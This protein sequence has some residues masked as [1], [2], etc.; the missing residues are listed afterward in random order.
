MCLYKSEIHHCL[1]PPLCLLRLLNFRPPPQVDYALGDNPRRVA[2]LGFLQRMLSEKEGEEVV[3]GFTRRP[4]AL[5]PLYSATIFLFNHHLLHSTANPRNLSLSDIPICMM[6]GYSFEEICEV[7]LPRT[8]VLVGK[9]GTELKKTALE[10]GQILNVIDTPGL[11]D[12][13]Q[14]VGQEIVSCIRMAR[15][16][17]DAF[18][19]VISIS[20]RF[21]ED[22]KAAIYTLRTLFGKEVYDYMIIVFTGGDGLE[23]N[24][25][26]VDFLRESPKALQETLGLCGDRYVLFDNKTKDPIKKSSQVRELLSLVNT[27]SKNNGGKPYTNEI[28]TELKKVT[29][30]LDEQ[31]ISACDEQFKRIFEMVEVEAQGVN[32][33]IR[34][35]IG[36]RAECSTEG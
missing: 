12:S 10:D 32:F 14:T 19:V 8:L 2:V 5:T 27:V 30:G 29:R 33:E 34:K 20:N 25:S 6:G 9:T 3:V 21:G 35:T 7:I 31:D 15:H 4:F 26:L 22:E 13:S 23:E 24:E 16:G 11:F 17:V 28:F 36:R 18:L 1:F